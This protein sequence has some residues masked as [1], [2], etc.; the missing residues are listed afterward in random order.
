[1]TLPAGRRSNE[2]E[3]AI[4]PEFGLRSGAAPQT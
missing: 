1:M 3:L 4:A 2:G